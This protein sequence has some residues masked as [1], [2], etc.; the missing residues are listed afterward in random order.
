MA[1]EAA[2][3]VRP[4]HSGVTCCV[5]IPRGCLL[6]DSRRR[7]HCGALAFPAARAAACEPAGCVA[8]GAAERSRGA[9]IRG[10][11]AGDA[12]RGIAVLGVCGRAVAS[13][14]I[15]A[16]R[17]ASA[18]VAVGGARRGSRGGL[19]AC[20]AGQ[21]AAGVA[22]VGLRAAAGIR[23]CGGSADDP[24]RGVARGGLHGPARAL[25]ALDRLDNSSGRVADHLPASLGGE[26]WGQGEREQDGEECLHEGGT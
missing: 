15:G 4:R 20:R 7:D 17:Q 24:A 11:T 23:V 1:C 13:P 22:I 10:L 8:L 14:G 21:P 25:L 26:H 5:G 2:A 9:G 19:G 6:L 16:T 12:S 3:A 18:G